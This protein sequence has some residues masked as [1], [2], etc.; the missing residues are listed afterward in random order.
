M[1]FII[2]TSFGIGIVIGLLLLS[3]LYVLLWGF[4]VV[5]L[6][7]IFYV[8]VWVGAFVLVVFA[9]AVFLIWFPFFMVGAFFVVLELVCSFVLEF[10]VYGQSAGVSQVALL[11]SV[12]F[13]AWLWG[14]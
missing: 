3:V 14:P 6:R 7:F 10:F 11:C 13:W 2:N 12:T 1:Q 4:L 8:G 5:V 9:L